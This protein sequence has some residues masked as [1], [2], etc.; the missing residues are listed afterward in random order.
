MEK[1]QRL[2][3]MQR[4]EGGKTRCIT[5][6]EEREVVLVVENWRSLRISHGEMRLQRKEKEE[7]GVLKRTRRRDKERYSKH[8]PS[9]SAQ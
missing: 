8:I 9:S 6:V 5:V 2:S 4:T 3:E 7:E 1:E